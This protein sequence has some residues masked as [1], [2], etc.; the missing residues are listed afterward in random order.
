MGFP[1]TIL[2]ALALLLGLAAEAHATLQPSSY[3]TTAGQAMLSC[4]GRPW[5][6]IL[7]YGADPTDTA[8][9][10][11]AIQSAVNDAV[12]NNVPVHMPAGKFKVSSQITIDYAG[13]AATGFRLIS[14]GATL[15]GSS[16]TS[17]PVLQV[18]CSGGTISSPAT[19]FYFHQEGTLFVIGNSNEIS[20]TTLTS[21]ATTGATVLNVASTANLHVGQTV[22]VGLASGG[23]FSSPIAALGSGNITLTT[24]LPSAASN[25]AVVGLPSYVFAMG[26]ADFSDQHNSWAIDHIDVKNNNIGSGAG[27][28][29]LNANYDSVFFGVCD[30]AGG[31][32]G[33][34]LEQTQFSKIAGAGS[35]AATGGTALVLENGYNFSNIFYALDLEVAPICIS[36]TDQHH[37]N[38]TWVSPYMNCTTAVNATASDNNVLI[39]PQYAGSV[40]NYGPQSVGIS[41]I[42]TGNRAKWLFPASATYQAA[43]VDDGL[44]VSSYNAPGASMTVTTPVISTVNAGWSIAVATDNGK[45]MTLNGN[46]APLIVGNKNV[47]QITLGPGNYEY[48]RVESDGNNWRVT[49]ITRNTLLLG[50]FQAPPWPSNWLYPATAGYSATLGDNGNVLSSYNTSSGLTV[51][52][53]P[54]AQLPSGWAIGFATDNNKPVSIN[55][56]DGHIVYPGS[57]ASRTTINLANTS[58]GAYEYL[59]LQYDNTSSGS[60]FRVVDA[61]P[62][63]WQALGAIGSAGFSH[64]TFP[65]TSA[66]QASLADNGNVLSSYNSPL[67]YFTM[68]LP[69]SAGLTM[70]WTIGLASDSNKTTSLQLSPGDSAR[71]LFPGSGATTTGLTLAPNNYE[72]AGLRYDGSNFRVTT[73]TPAS[74]TAIGILGADF[75]L[76]RFNF[77]SAAN[78]TAQIADGGN[79]LS[80]YNTSGGL[81]VTLPAVS[82]IYPGWTMGFMT[83]NGKPLTINTTGPALILVPA[84]GGG[85]TGSLML[86]AGNYEFVQLKSDGS[87]WRIISMTPSTANDLGMITLPTSCAVPGSGVL[88]NSAGTVKVC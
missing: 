19:C 53:P 46:G 32:G 8:D 44:A 75:S 20:E 35:A 17:G 41:V 1:R 49:N 51:T 24:G 81:T 5:I 60:N 84:N 25:G 50:G 6:D 58:Q 54:T 23:T 74:A 71:I 72:F 37:G 40:V 73:I 42:G 61:T 66:Y 63:T 29:Q 57:G 78:Y 4:S 76:N 30:S 47:S 52:L 10:T 11:S 48:V 28:C 16:I 38:N 34:A 67:G 7:C 77:P 68:T 22:L 79:T 33:I 87:N 59:V 13:D 36:I 88:Y 86:G 31:A 65:A 15:D 69:A 3:P 26:K 43:A 27:A 39:N 85:Q 55:V 80:S 45:G 82:S 2:L 18:E 12:T 70:G 62:A 14:G 56:S 83:D 64:W 9:S 21:S